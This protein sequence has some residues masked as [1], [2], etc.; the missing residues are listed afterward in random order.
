MNAV[1]LTCDRS[2]AGHGLTDGRELTP[3]EKRSQ[4]HAPWES[5]RFPDKRAIRLTVELN[6]QDVALVR[7]PRW[8]RGRLSTTWYDR[9]NR[10][11]G[12]ARTWFLYWGVIPPDRIVEGFDLRSDCPLP[13]DWREAQALQPEITGLT[14]GGK[15]SPNRAG[16]VTLTFRRN[17]TIAI[18][19][20]S[21]PDFLPILLAMPPR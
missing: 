19:A 17:G 21:F 15:V 11:G 8:A 7:W 2:P 10:T 18:Q 9:L 16:P 12:K 3:E 5:A 20:D 14:I 1:W 6:D 13:D 4:G